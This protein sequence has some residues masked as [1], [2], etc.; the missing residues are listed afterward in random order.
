MLGAET[1]H[2]KFDMTEPERLLE[3]AF[4]LLNEEDFEQMRVDTQKLVV[5]NEQLRQRIAQLEFHIVTHGWA[6][7]KLH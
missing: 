2:C 7:R 5:E 6:E 4:P 1:E 3:A